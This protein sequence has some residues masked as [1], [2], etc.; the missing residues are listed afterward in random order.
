MVSWRG[1]PK[2]VVSGNGTNF[3]GAVRELKELVQSIDQEQV[4]PSV[5]D[6]GVKSRFNMSAAP[7]FGGVFE[8]MI[9]APKK[10]IY[11]I[12]S[13]SDIRDEELLTTFCRSRVLDQLQAVNHCIGKLQKQHT[14]DTEPLL[15]W[16]NGWSVCSVACQ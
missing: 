1:L 9:K 10:V 12:L 11:A 13:S 4:Q 5:A 7:H 8:C 15:I 16:S 6:S 3:T 2:E 14:T